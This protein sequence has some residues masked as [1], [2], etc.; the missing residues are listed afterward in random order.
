MTNKHAF[1]SRFART[2]CLGATLLLAACSGS[3]DE[4]TTP[5]GE[6][7]AD[8]A[9]P[10]ELA[11]SDAEPMSFRIAV[12]PADD[13]TVYYVG[14]TTR[15][16]FDRLGSAQAVAEAF[17][18]IEK[19]HDQIDWTTPDDKLLFR[20]P[21]TF[22]AAD[23]WELRPKTEYAV[24]VFGVEAEG[25]I[26]TDAVHGFAATTAVEASENRLTVSVAENSA[27]VKVTTTNDDPYFLDCIEASRI[28]GY[29]VE[30]LAEHLIGSYGPT[31]GECIETGGVE[32]DFM[33]LLEE[34]TDYCAVAF[35]YLGGYPTT[36]IVVVPFHTPGGELVPQDCT[37]TAE[38]TNITIQGATVSVHPSNPDTD[39]FWVVYNTTLIDS[40]RRNEGIPK[41]IDD[42]LAI[43]AES[44]SEQYG[45]EI[46]P[47]KA[48]EIVVKKGDDQYIYNDFS[49]DTEYCV[50]AVGLDKKARQTT[51]VYVS[52][53][54]RTL[55]P[56][57][58]A[59]EPF[60]CTI[61][62]DG[63]TDDGMSITVTPADKQAT[64]VGLLAE[65][66]DYAMFSSDAEFLEDML[67]MWTEEA[68]G[69]YMTLVELFTEYG[70]FL[71][72]DASYIFPDECRPGTLYLAFVF[73]MNEE[74]ETTSGMQKQ[75]F[76]VDEEGAAHPAEAPA[77][78]AARTA[79]LKREVCRKSSF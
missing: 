51:E 73:G 3:D 1:L 65:A 69:N 70:F 23:M 56:G 27:R 49:P 40:Y 14:V 6:G 39:Y 10:F 77:A 76:T 55:K 22:Y 16:D 38:V 45:I 32:R 68:S 31:I 46:T 67:L 74:G 63:M 66:D 21:K 19:K 29:P 52:E 24:V 62:A 12:T 2:L 48:A 44:L 8:P 34:D 50:L 15:T 58:D 53:P 17:I 7:P 61:T 28:E 75:F 4:T 57:G 9:R 43:I 41:L 5:P 25:V 54:F 59:S 42:G 36:D 37:F 11:L 18:E 33:R 47:A 78:A 35:G 79:L 72:G 13:A 71:Q 64:Y 60:D 26:S 20:G 30:K